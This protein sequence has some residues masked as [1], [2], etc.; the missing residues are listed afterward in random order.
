LFC[1]FGNQYIVLKQTNVCYI[2]ILKGKHEIH[3]F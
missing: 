2:Y 3:Q 1:H